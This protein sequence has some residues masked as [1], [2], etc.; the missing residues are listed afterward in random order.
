MPSLRFNL[1]NKNHNEDEIES[2][3]KKLKDDND[4][5]EVERSKDMGFGVGEIVIGIR[6]TEITYNLIR[7]LRDYLKRDDYLEFKCGKTKV[8][9]EGKMTPEQVKTVYNSLCPET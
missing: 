7:K 9:I 4:I 2:L 5:N 6:V 3:M 1:I 8:K